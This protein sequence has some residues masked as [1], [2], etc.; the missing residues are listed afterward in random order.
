MRVVVV[1]LGV[2]GR[3]RRDIAGVDCIATVD[4]ENTSADFSDI[5]SVP[6]ESFDAAL[7][8]IPDAPKFEIIKYLL[9][10]KKHVLVEKPLWTTTDLKIEELQKIALN[11]SVICYTAYNHRFEPHYVSA[12]KIIE[13]GKLGKIYHCR[14]FYGNGTA[15][16]VRDSAWRDH[17][18]GV[19]HDLGSHML[20]T[21]I[22]W[23]GSLNEDLKIYSSRRFEN[24]S[25]DH[26]VF[27][28]STTTGVQIEVEVTLLSWRNNF[29][30]DIYA[31]NGSLH[32]ESLCKW[33]PTRLI[34][35]TRV[36]PSG[37]PI[38]VVDDLEQADPTWLNEYDY[39][40]KLVG[41]GTT[42]M[43]TDIWINRVL[44]SLGEEA[45]RMASL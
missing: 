16:Q 27:G 8:C 36:L 13:S 14:V 20:D 42:N 26:V 22:Y 19:L 44:R 43:A 11:N 21:A 18:S 38:E 31:E 39:F 25:P 23:F 37:R 41:R 24:L 12:K 5:K 6:V 34:H 1:G 35:R 2:Q 4:V 32:I 17:G 29:T 10:N 28:G 33:G 7:C 45:I 9:E 15:R 30:C 3:K 40:K